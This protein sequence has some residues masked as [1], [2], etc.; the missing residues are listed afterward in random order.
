MVA[1]RPRRT[2]EVT[3]PT[4]H[5]VAIFARPTNKRPPEQLIL[6]R[7]HQE[8][9]R[10][11]AEEVTKY[12]KICDLKNDWE[13][14]TDKRIQLNTVK[15]RVN[16]LL[17]AN[18][19]AIEER[20]DRLRSLLE[21]EEKQ[22]LVEMDAKEETVLER[23]AKM[24]EK[25]KALKEKRERERL[26]LVQEKLEQQWRDQCEEL[27]STLSKRQ[28]DQVAAERLQQLEIK[29]DMEAAATAGDQ[30]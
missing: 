9:M 25:A 24:R 26:N 28:Q 29:A 10:Q 5:S 7:R 18:Q 6:D 11:Q 1:Q 13:R 23:Q 14:S 15:R 2:R 8:D 3:G 4:P 19:F 17:Q 20:R 16:S 30:S 21:S 22:Y 27:R 12:N